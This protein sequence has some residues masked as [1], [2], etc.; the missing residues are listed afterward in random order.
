MTKV[1][2]LVREGK[3]IK[4]RVRLVDE[5][6]EMQ[7]ESQEKHCFDVKHKLFKCCCCVDSR[8][9]VVSCEPESKR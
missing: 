4:K 1:F 6:K 2:L 8:S 7:N 5:K 9:Y 3:Q